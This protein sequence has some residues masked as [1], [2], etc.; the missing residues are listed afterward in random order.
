M[1]RATWKGPECRSLAGCLA[2][3]RTSVASCAA[4]LASLAAIIAAACAPPCAHAGDHA[5]EHAAEYAGEYAEEHAA[6]HAAEYAAEYA[7][8]HAGES[9]DEG[10]PAGEHAGQGAPAPEQAHAAERPPAREH[11]VPLAA[12]APA[13]DGRIDPEEWAAA[14]RLDGFLSAGG[15][16]RRR[17]RAWIAAT[18]DRLLFAISSELPA[19]GEIL[20]ECRRDVES[21]VFD[22]S[23]EVWIDPDPGAERG[24]TF[25]MLA[26]SLGHRWYRLHPRGGTPE[27]PSWRGDWR[28]ENGFHDGAWHCEVS[29]PVACIAGVTPGSSSL[30]DAP[31]ASDARA[32]RADEGVWAVNLCR[33]WKQEWSWSSLSGESYRPTERFVFVRSAAPAVRME[34]RGD[35]FAGDVRWALAVANPS[36]EPLAVRT[37]L[38]LERDLM[39]E[40][41]VSE[42]LDLAPGESREVELRVDDRATRRFRLSAR[43]LSPDGETAFLERS[44]AWPAAGAWRWTTR[45]KVIPPVDFRF[46]Y[47]PYLDRLRVLADASNLPRGARLETLS[48]VV[49]KKGGEL[50]KVLELGDLAGGRREIE[51]ALPP[52]EGEYEI[53]LKAGGPGVPDAEVVKT[54]ERRVFEWERNALGKTRKVYPPFTPLRVEGRTVASVLRE[55]SMDATGL[56]RQVTA[57]GRPLLAGP[58]R[59][60]VRAG[61]ADLEVEPGELR[62]A[63]VADDEVVAETSWTAG[64]LRAAVRCAWD[65][66]GMM[67]VDLRYWP[68][69]GGSAPIDS[70][71]RASPPGTPLPR[72]AAPL[73]RLSL[74]IPLEAAAATHIHAMGDGIRNTIY[75]RLAETEGVIWT[76]REVQASDLPESFASYLYVGT[77]L[78]GLS[79]FAECDRGWDRDPKTPNVEIVRKGG[80]VEIRVHI[81]NRPPGGGAERTLQGERT[82]PPERALQ[83]RRAPAEEPALA[84]ERE[85]TFGL[86][87]APVKP[88]IPEDWR[89]R[90]RRDRYSLLGTDINWLALGDCGSVYPAGSELFF[91]EMIARGNRERLGEEDI[92]RVVERGKPYFE[93]YGPERVAAFVNHARFNLTARHGTRMVF[94]YNRASYQAAAEFETFKD[95]WCLTDWRDIGKGDGIHEIK[96][97]PTDSYI[98]HALWWYGKSFD[99]GGNRGVYWD[100]WFFVGSYNTAMTG[101]YRRPDGSVSPSN[102]LWGLRELAKRTFQYMNERGMFP[103]T[104]PHMTSTGILPLLSFATVQYDWE[105][106]YSEGDVQGRFPREYILLVSSGELAGTWP[107]LLGDHGKLADDPPTARTFAAVAMVHELDC[108]Y[109]G[110]SRSGKAQL[111]LFRP[112]DEILARPG[113]RTHRYWDEEPQPAAASD[114]DLPAIVYSVPGEEAVVAV[115]SYAGEDRTADLRVDAAALG[116]AGGF[117]AID[118][119]T[120]EE[121]APGGSASG[122]SFRLPRHDVRVLRLVPR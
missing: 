11:R 40:V 59:W 26:N 88:R 78:R 115:V 118:A 39:P 64:P 41:K 101:A 85:I 72:A 57:A 14:C 74:V 96:I 111:A 2:S 22:D 8:E 120:G 95:E 68:E 102:G 97:V 81:V 103:L 33:N 28:V 98:D 47:Y 48:G 83:A 116:F 5:G 19:E 104:M 30:P 90:W 122:I 1:H 12:E 60:E 6:E 42:L 89:H 54:F 100:N 106:K 50:V 75:E 117:R 52:L 109:P 35:G 53:A 55:H 82:L 112:V 29:V 38:L 77:P 110:Y 107:V 24:R 65:Y 84:A 10:A 73:E 36:P 67:R 7:G 9:V 71:S 25:Q 87:A 80:V 49:R 62:F 3:S 23:V 86:L 79:W 13:I 58:M 69:P 44:V 108:A 93:P 16:E 32:R 15:L 27:D 21:L 92:R 119:E 105:W 37:E 66:D 61:G 20:A 46:A 94:Y 31:V 18:E 91:W 17:A 4:R 63:S 43:A 114:P 56:W 51:V 34:D 45:R 76:A 113:V 99:V 70:A 121:V